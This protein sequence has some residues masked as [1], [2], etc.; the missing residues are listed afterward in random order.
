MVVFPN[1]EVVVFPELICVHSHSQYL[2]LN[3][4]GRISKVV[5]LL[6]WSF[7][8]VLLYV[9]T[10]IVPYNPEKPAWQKDHL[11]TSTTS[12]KRSQLLG[13]LRGLIDKVHCTCMYMYIHT[14]SM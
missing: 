9:R 1:S 7:S 10:Y 13:P 14:Y 12:L 11:Y 4:S 8:G 2:G 6:R 5:A 3:Q